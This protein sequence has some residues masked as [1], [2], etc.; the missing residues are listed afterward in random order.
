MDLAQIDKLSS[1]NSGI[2]YLM[3]VVDLFSRF[4]RVGP[5]RNK[6]AEASKACFI[7][8]CSDKSSLVFPKKLW[9]D[10]GK[11]FLADFRNFCEDAGIKVYSIH[12]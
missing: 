6:S 8:L 5:M 12:S 10:Q 7:K 2:K 9:I 4:V 3:V 11:E 1:A